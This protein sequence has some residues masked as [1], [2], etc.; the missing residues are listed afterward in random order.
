MRRI[1]RI[2]ARKAQKAS[3]LVLEHPLRPG[4]WELYE[5]KGNLQ[6]VYLGEPA[7]KPDALETLSRFIDNPENTMT[8]K[9]MRKIN[10]TK[11]PILC[12]RKTRHR[13]PRVKPE[14]LSETQ[15]PPQKPQNL[16][17]DKLDEWAQKAHAW[18]RK[19]PYDTY[20][21]KYSNIYN[22]GSG[23]LGKKSHE[24]KSG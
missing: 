12:K 6:L 2:V 11:P 13:Q 19:A 1:G 15:C 24:K 22:R 8:L 5:Y 4:I 16:Q 14:K 9:E 18:R 10:E 20:A 17:W 7:V 3:V 23:G 21:P